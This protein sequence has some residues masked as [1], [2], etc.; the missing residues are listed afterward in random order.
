M[1]IHRFG[2]WITGEVVLDD[3]GCTVI[4]PPLGWPEGAK[5]IIAIENVP[6]P[7]EVTPAGRAMLK[8]GE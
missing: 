2:K 4:Y 7:Y 5:V 3:Q 6:I 8:D 1:S